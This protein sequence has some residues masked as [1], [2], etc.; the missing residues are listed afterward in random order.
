[1]VTRR[2]FVSTRPSV[3]SPSPPPSCGPSPARW[4]GAVGKVSLYSF[5]T[6]HAYSVWVLPRAGAAEPSGEVRMSCVGQRGGALEG[7]RECCPCPPP[8]MVDEIYKGEERVGEGERKSEVY[9]LAT[10]YIHF[11][12]GQNSYALQTEPCQSPCVTLNHPPT[13]F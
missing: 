7:E 10:L 13:T 5:Y 11:P 4:S 3:S 12:H 9:R 8:I 6:Q 1:M 2:I